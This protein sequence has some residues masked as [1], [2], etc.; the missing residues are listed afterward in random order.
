MDSSWF[1]FNKATIHLTLSIK[2]HKHI[3]VYPKWNGSGN[4]TLTTTKE[5]A[6][7]YRTKGVPAI[8]N[9]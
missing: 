1:G 3:I 5:D 2:R 9:K 4:D 8:S 6:I 7:S